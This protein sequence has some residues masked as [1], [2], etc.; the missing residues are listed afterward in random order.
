[1]LES[2]ERFALLSNH[3]PF[4]LVYR[5]S[6][7]CANEQR[8]EEKFC[9]SRLLNVNL[10]IEEVTRVVSYFDV[11]SIQATRDQVLPWIYFN[12]P[13]PT[14]LNLRF[15]FVT[16]FLAAIYSLNS[17]MQ[18]ACIEVLQNNTPKYTGT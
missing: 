15:G 16:F 7:T 11:Q 5:F 2:A 13:I 10:T 8:W 1:M 12:K 14:V 18:T 9:T 3:T 6:M 4:P 17:A